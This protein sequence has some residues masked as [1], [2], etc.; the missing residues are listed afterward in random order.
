MYLSP[1][2]DCPVVVTFTLIG[3]VDNPPDSVT[4]TST[5]PE[6]SEPVY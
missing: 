6:D 2:V 5:N 3:V 1:F 4:V